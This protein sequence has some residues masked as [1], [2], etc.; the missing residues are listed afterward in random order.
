MSQLRRR[1]NLFGLTMI[2][3]GS[4]VGAGIFVTPG[5]VAEGLPHAGYLLIVWAIGGLVALT[6]ALTFAELAGRF[7]L[8]GG[9]Y[10]YLREAY[11]KLTA[12]AYGWA[13]LFIINTGSMAALAL[14]F[15]NYLN[16]LIPLS[17]NGQIVVAVGLLSVL[18]L[19]NCLGVE[20]SQRMTSAFT[21]AKLLGILAV[22][23]LAFFFS[24]P[25]RG[26]QLWSLQEQVPDPLITVL[27]TAL[28]GV[29]WSFGGWHHASYVAGEAIHPQRTVPRAMLLGTVIVTLTYLLINLAY[30]LLYTPDQMAA[31][32][33]IAAEAVNS[34]WS[35]GGDW[36][37]GLVAISI[38]GTL[39]IYCMSAPRIYFAMAQDKSFIPAI[40]KLHPRFRTPARAMLLQCVWAILLIFFWGN[41]RDLLHYVVF[42][43]VL[44]MA[45]A[46]IALFHF[47]RRMGSSSGY[48]VWGFPIIP[49]IFIGISLA[50][51]VNKLIAEP[52]HALVGFCVI[53]IG[54]PVFLLQ[55]TD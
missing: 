50:F 18:T 29:L 48:R 25:E 31:S 35:G 43:D 14:A 21:V 10:I 46:A 4:C 42:M 16:E 32:D 20:Q 41:I 11:G 45:L 33:R 3:V 6:G 47:R 39:A 37:A 44:F 19:I 51:C 7:P 28:V 26:S 15:S 13:I 27:L 12:F 36:V 5:E 9:V 40:A 55:K 34:V 38:A 2:A 52:I 1:L 22:V 54:L 49:L 30:L 17:S 8:S 23:M 24:E 53:V